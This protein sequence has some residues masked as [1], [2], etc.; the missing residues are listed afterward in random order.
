M[1]KIEDFPKL[2]KT[3]TLSQNN[4]FFKNM[5]IL[6]NRVKYVAFNLQ[7][8]HLH[9]GLFLKILKLWKNTSIWWVRDAV[10]GQNIKIFQINQI[11]K[12]WKIFLNCPKQRHFLKT[13]KFLR[14]LVFKKI[15]QSKLLLICKLNA[16]NLTYFW[17]YWNYGR[18]P[19]FGE[20]KIQKMGQ[21]LRSFKSIKYAKNR[22][23]SLID[24]NKGTSSKH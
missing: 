1:P 20:S 2:T 7:T 13:T 22:R 14:I 10:N 18:L 4:I 5:R 3:K 11:C 24:Q 16:F 19:Q 12:K 8:K 9:L 21:I 23:F 17:K 6:K 15:G